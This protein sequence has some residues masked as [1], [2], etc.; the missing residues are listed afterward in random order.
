MVFLGDAP[1]FALASFGTPQGGKFWLDI[2]I[3]S[4]EASV[5][6]A[7]QAAADC[8]EARQAFVSTLWP[9][10]AVALEPLDAGMSAHALAEL[11]VEV[12]FSPEIRRHLDHAEEADK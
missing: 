11:P 5:L 7:A 8:P 3:G 12:K 2:D 10:A 1:G 9:D 4:L 6:V